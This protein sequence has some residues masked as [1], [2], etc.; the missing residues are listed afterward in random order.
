[1]QSPTF[2]EKQETAMQR[3]DFLGAA[4]L[5]A[6]AWGAVSA[7]TTAHAATPPDPPRLQWQIWSRHLQWVS[8]QAQTAQDPYGVGVLVG[9][10]ALASGYA[11]VGLTVR[12][13][14]HVDPAQVRTHLPLMLRGIRSTGCLCNHIG[15][16]VNPSTDADDTDWI[17]A[18]RVHE[19]LSV[20]SANGIQRYRCANRSFAG[21]TF[22]TQ[23]Q[24]QLEGLR[25]NYQRLAEINQRYQLNALYHT[26]TSL[27]VT[28]WEFLRVLQGPL[29]RDGRMDYQYDPYGSVNKPIDP[30]L[31]GV[32]FAIG[33]V[34]REMP[35]NGWQT[36]LRYALPHVR[37]VAL[38]APQI[39][40]NATTGR[41]QNTVVPAAQSHIDFTVFFRWL[42]LGAY[43]GASEVQ[44]EHSIVGALGTM[45]SLNNAFFADHAQ[46]VSGNLT[47]EI[48]VRE[49]KGE[50]DFY[51]IKA[52]EAG[53]SASQMT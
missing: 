50:V 39:N 4:T 7:A 26:Q 5:G 52:L 41:L 21:D 36:A 46:F 10:Y 53:W 24:D 14:G 51:K 27:G 19:V 11:A 30:R 8:T 31:V 32:N 43:N 1:V 47:P 3:R 34:G 13:G 38:H 12:N 22:G 37:G 25:A 29:P 28:V 35:L 17:G 40:R 9:Q 45:V 16:D 15:T 6:A 2:D 20:A 23:M 44:V 18:Q 48:M 49:M 33:H 42:L